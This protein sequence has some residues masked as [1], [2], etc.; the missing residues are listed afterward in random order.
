[1]LKNKVDMESLNMIAEAG[2]PIYTEL[3]DSLGVT[4]EEMM[5]MSSAG[6]IASS[7]LEDAFK[8]MTSEGG[9]FFNGME[10]ASKT[11]SGKMSTL[12]DNIA[13]TAASIGKQ[14]LPT[15]KPLIDRAIEMAGVVREWVNNN[16]GLINQKIQDFIAGVTKAVKVLYKLWDSGLI[17]AIAAGVITFMAIIKAMKTYAAVMQTVKA[18]QIAFNIAASANPIGLIIIGVG[19]LVAATVLLIKNWEKVK[20]VI[21]GVW[22]KIKAPFEKVSEFFGGIKGTSTDVNDAQARGAAAGGGRFNTAGLVSGNAG[23]MQNQTTTVNRSTVDITMAGLPQGSSVQQRGKAPG[24]NL[25][26]AFGGGGL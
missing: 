26:Y 17:P 23:M 11:L 21:L 3:A 18:I 2:V 22:E 20:E 1:M 13:L 4:V 7:D 6:N 24:V 9:I 14:L 25:N 12:K 8:N 16:Q 10:I 5:K 19:L 15:I